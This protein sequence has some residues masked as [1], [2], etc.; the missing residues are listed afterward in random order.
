[1]LTD[2]FS[3]VLSRNMAVVMIFQ[4][5]SV[6][7]SDEYKMLYILNLEIS[8]QLSLTKYCQYICQHVQSTQYRTHQ[9]LLV[10]TSKHKDGAKITH[11]LD[12][13]FNAIF[14]DVFFI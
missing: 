12:A 6:T 11:P 2:T 1:M 5:N 10:T 14:G 13:Q 9:T 3:P 7:H 8:L 4:E